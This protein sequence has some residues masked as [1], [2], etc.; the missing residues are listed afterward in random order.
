MLNSS[1]PNSL[2]ALPCECLI[3]LLSF[4][5]ASQLATVSAV[6]RTLYSAANDDTLWQRLCLVNY[7]VEAKT[8]L[9]VFPYRTIRGFY[10]GVL[11]RYGWM[12]GL[13]QANYPFFTGQLLQVRINPTDASII[14]EN[15]SAT[16]I[17]PISEQQF[18]AIQ[19]VSVD[20][21]QLSLSRTRVFEICFEPCGEGLHRVSPSFDGP[22]QVSRR[23]RRTSAPLENTED[24]I[25]SAYDQE[26]I[27]SYTICFG[28]RAQSTT[29]RKHM[30][31]VDDGQE[32][33]RSYQLCQDHFPY[34]R[35]SPS[36][37]LWPYPENSRVLR[38]EGTLITMFDSNEP[39]LAFNPLLQ[40]NGELEDASWEMPA[41]TLTIHCPLKC[42]EYGVRTVTLRAPEGELRFK[43]GRY[44]TIW[45]QIKLDA[46]HKSAIAP[47]NMVIK[48]LEGIWAGTYGSHGIEYVLLRYE[49]VANA[50]DASVQ[51]IHLVFYKITGDVNVPRGEVSCRVNLGDGTGIP[52]IGDSRIGDDLAE[53]GTEL[54]DDASKIFLPAL[55]DPE[56]QTARAY[57]GRG[58][59]AMAGYRNPTYIVNDAI[60][61]SETK[62]AIYW[63]DLKR[64]SS[65]VKVALPV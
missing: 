28:N 44:Q 31:V 50:L 40:T 36:T 46:N 54:N 27:S 57:H 33:F 60:I 42:H 43:T 56:F 9:H 12:L 5:S 32:T 20:S 24:A 2:T 51:D 4:L 25:G 39:P 59:V 11:A 1:H 55:K 45:S 29:L 35:P 65:F 19:G 17:S 22:E 3:H 38:A 49:W 8:H 7:K 16:N 41:N 37:G 13:W 52:W 26:G 48:P 14:G 62:I 10:V 18:G 58:T 15:L 47:S 61:L 30:S 64:I 34:F 23:R 21:L 53:D 63:H 6:S